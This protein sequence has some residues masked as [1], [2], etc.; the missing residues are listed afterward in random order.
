[1]IPREKTKEEQGDP[2]RPLQDAAIERKQLLP[3]FE[4]AFFVSFVVGFSFWFPL[5]IFYFSSFSTLLGL[6]LVPLIMFDLVYFEQALVGY[7]I[8]VL[9]PEPRSRLF[10]F[11]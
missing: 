3:N 2:L 4:V 11:R 6:L 7:L 1:M 5:Y 8:Y 9:F 10:S